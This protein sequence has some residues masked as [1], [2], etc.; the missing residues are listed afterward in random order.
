MSKLSSWKSALPLEPNERQ[1]TQ[2]T[3]KR[4]RNLHR[5]VKQGTFCNNVRVEQAPLLISVVTAKPEIKERAAVEAENRERK[6]AGRRKVQK[7][8]RQRENQWTKPLT[9]QVVSKPPGKAGKKVS[10]HN[11]P[12]SWDK[13]KSRNEGRAK[14]DKLAEATD[15]F[16]EKSGSN[17]SKQ[18]LQSSHA[19]LSGK[20]ATGFSS[21]NDTNPTAGTSINTYD[22]SPRRTASEN[23]GSNEDADSNTPLA[24][25]NASSLATIG[26][27]PQD[28]MASTSSGLARSSGKALQNRKKIVLEFPVPSHGSKGIELP[29]DLESFGDLSSVGS[30]PSIESDDSYDTRM[31]KMMQRWVDLNGDF[32]S[33]TNHARDNERIRLD[34]NMLDHVIMA[35]PNLEEA[36]DVFEGMSGVKPIVVGPLQGLGVRTAHVGLDRNRYIEIIAPDNDCPTPLGAELGSLPPGILT[37]YHYAIRSTETSRFIEGYIYDVLGWDPD[38]IVMVQGLEDGTIRQWDLL[39]MYG[40]DV[41]GAAPM[42]VRYTD[43][44]QHPSTVVASN[45]TLQSCTVRAREEHLVHKL[46]TDVGGINVEYADDHALEF[47]FDT[48]KG[49]LTLSSNRPNGLVFPGFST[50]SSDSEQLVRIAS[51]HSTTE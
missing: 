45:L 30:W 5:Q 24:D 49:P 7:N 33:G 10:I 36:M 40:H 8:I 39:T 4:R 41:G 21:D 17:H 38:H 29:V 22:I 25:S 31:N 37:P 23:K 1:R 32:E 16:S 13:R 6:L 9:G 35:A 15:S 19:A 48:P 14:Y 26:K 20:W 12:S 51:S 3:T 50:D 18:T 11:I 47:T 27:N 42:Y 2:N 28:D 46:I 34:D 44:T 43:E